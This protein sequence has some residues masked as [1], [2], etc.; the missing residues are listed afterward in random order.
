MGGGISDKGGE[1]QEMK[2]DLDGLYRI[3]AKCPSCREDW[4]WGYEKNE[5]ISFAQARAE[6]GE[7]LICYK[8][9]RIFPFT[10]LMVQLVA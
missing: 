5:L 6:K 7:S 8:C 4:S 3:H 2:I 1:G 9:K 10:V